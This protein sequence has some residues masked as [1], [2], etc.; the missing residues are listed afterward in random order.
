[1]FCRAAFLVPLA[2]S[3]WGQP[4]PISVH[5][6]LAVAMV[7]LNGQGPF[8]MLIDT[9]AT[10]SSIRPQVARALH[11]APEYRVAEVTPAGERL[12]PG[13]KSV[14]VE[15]GDRVERGVE[16]AWPESSGLDEAGSPVDGVLG[17]SL[18][19]RF[20]YLLDYKSRQ[21]VVGAS[22]TPGKRVQ[23]ESAASRMLLAAVSPE[24]GTIHLVLDSAASNVLL[25]HAHA[26]EISRN[27]G[28]LIAMNSRRAAT[29]VRIPALLVGGHLLARL[30][31]LV[32]S[33]AGN[34]EKEDGLL[35]AGL[36]R[37]VYVSNSEG[38]VKLGR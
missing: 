12:I 10:S 18:L 31:A 22:E 26:S 36:F 25:W 30:D 15:I 9:G 17:Q 33:R 37:S 21:L 23:F 7:R 1:M 28:E 32:L 14:S 35:P 29:M 38:Y 4:V 16:F 27:S 6:A 8:R 34:H 19:S 2:A 13:G 20:N 3:L 11:L 5:G 24:E